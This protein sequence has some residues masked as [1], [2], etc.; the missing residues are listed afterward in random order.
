[1]RT[2]VTTVTK[3]HAPQ[4]VANIQKVLCHGE[5]SS[6]NCYLQEDLTD[7][8]SR[9]MNVIKHI[10]SKESATQS[11]TSDAPK[12]NP[13]QATKDGDNQI[14]PE[15]CDENTL[16]EIPNDDANPGTS[17]QAITQETEV[18]EG[19]TNVI[20]PTTINQTP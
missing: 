20:P 16:Q 4:E 2:F 5:K 10:T 19:S 6:R 13:P 14:Q 1:M 15:L 7:T 8:A 18:D 3:R 9:A 17:T 11:D 12:E